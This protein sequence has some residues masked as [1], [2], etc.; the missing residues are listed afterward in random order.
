[1]QLAI[2]QEPSGSPRA[3]GV[4]ALVLAA[5]I[6]AAPIFRISIIAETARFASSPPAARASVSTRGMI[7]QEIPHWSLH[8]PQ[9]LSSPPFAA[10]AF[11]KRSV[12]S[13]LSVEIWRS[14]LYIAISSRERVT[15]SID[16]QDTLEGPEVLP[17]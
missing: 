6:A 8:Q 16:A 13:W 15:W 3:F 1:M 9:A 7:C 4:G 12:S 17:A 5:S 14:V 2:A 11:Q 10:M